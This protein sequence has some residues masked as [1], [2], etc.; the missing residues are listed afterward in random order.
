[1]DILDKTLPALPNIPT[2]WAHDAVARATHA[3]EPLAEPFLAARRSRTNRW[4][5]V[6]TPSRVAIGATVVVLAG[7]AVLA[8]RDTGAK[9]PATQQPGE[10]QKMRSVA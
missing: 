8:L 2:E 4:T 10:P 9:Q 3:L 1:M 6:L 5:A 7:L